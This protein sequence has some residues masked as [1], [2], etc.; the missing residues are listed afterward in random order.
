MGEGAIPLV[1][2]SCELRSHPISNQMKVIEPCSICVVLF[3]TVNKV[4]QILTCDSK[5]DEGP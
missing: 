3:K 2:A 5:I 4:A 1:F